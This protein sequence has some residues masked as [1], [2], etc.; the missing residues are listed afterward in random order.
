[1]TGPLSISNQPTLIATKTEDSW[2][3]SFSFDII[4]NNSLRK[5]PFCIIDCEKEEKEE[6]E[7]EEREEENDLLILFLESIIK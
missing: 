3:P 6:E 2:A 5:L 7:E 1:M 4:E